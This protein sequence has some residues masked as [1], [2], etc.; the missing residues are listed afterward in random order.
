MFTISGKLTR[1]CLSLFGLMI[2]GFVFVLIQITLC[3][4]TIFDE[5]LCP[6][7]TSRLI[8]IAR[9]LFGLYTPRDIGGNF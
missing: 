2:Q 3:S 4:E 8:F 6:A 7:E 9:Q 5:E 1:L